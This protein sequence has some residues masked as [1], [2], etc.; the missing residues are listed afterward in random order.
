[1][2]QLQEYFSVTDLVL[3]KKRVPFSKSQIDFM[4]FCFSE[5]N[6]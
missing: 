4:K 6:I 3:K 5:K 2:D 1:M